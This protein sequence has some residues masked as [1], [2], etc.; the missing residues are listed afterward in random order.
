MIEFTWQELRHGAENGSESNFGTPTLDML[1]LQLTRFCGSMERNV[2]LRSCSLRREH[3]RYTAKKLA[4][5][6]ISPSVSRN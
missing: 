4:G 5:H 3:L 1:M 2:V 6:S